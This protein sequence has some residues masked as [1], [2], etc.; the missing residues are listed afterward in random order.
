MG[1]LSNFA[2]WTWTIDPAALPAGSAL[3]IPAWR[4]SDGAAFAIENPSVLRTDKLPVCTPNT[5]ITG[6][7]PGVV[8]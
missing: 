1:L 7:P 6:P 5:P 2:N 4:S 8:P 3:L